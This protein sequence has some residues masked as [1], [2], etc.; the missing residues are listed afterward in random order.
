M[1][2]DS[3]DSCPKGDL[4]WISSEMTDHDS[5]GCQ[6]AVEDQDDDNDGFY[7]VVDACPMGEPIGIQALRITIQMDVMMLWKI[8]MM[9]MMVSLMNKIHVQLVLNDCG[10]AT[11]QMTM[12]GMV[13]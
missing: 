12:M 13:V 1:L 11:Q 6:D 7:D 8:K 5:D 4:G 2:L 10:L 9:I 3:V